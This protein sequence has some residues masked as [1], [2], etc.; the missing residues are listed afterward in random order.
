MKWGP[1]KRN[2]TSKTKV[3][4][5]KKLNRNDTNTNKQAA[6]TRLPSGKIVL[7]AGACLS[8][9]GL[10]ASGA[11]VGAA[12]ATTTT[13]RGAIVAVPTTPL[14]D[15]GTN[16]TAAY[17][18]GFGNDWAGLGA[19]FSLTVQNYAKAW[20]NGWKTTPSGRIA[21]GAYSQNYSKAG[22]NTG[23]TVK[24]LKKSVQ[25]VGFS[26]NA[27]N[28]NGVQR[29]DYC[30]KVAGF[31][32]DSG[33]KAAQYDWNIY[34]NKTFFSCSTVVTFGYVPVTFTGSL[35]GAANIYLTL[36]LNPD[37]VGLSGAGLAGIWGSASAGVGLPMLN[38]G[39]KAD[40]QLGNT[41]VDA[42][43]SI[44]PTTLSGKVD[45]IFDPVKIDLDVAVMSWCSTL[46]D[47]ELASYSSP[48]YT[49]P[50]IQF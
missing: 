42:S 21:T 19:D 41:M 34:V 5:M 10:A 6:W 3:K 13:T 49:W 8:F 33:S 2:K 14:P 27:Q 9:S 30:L 25:A 37:G 48:S 12:S 4:I 47:Y 22:I 45:L 18:Y 31:T 38:V 15:V 11:I 28:A 16:R 46:F 32:V 1:K 44:A 35:G 36:G 17:H 20:T 24:F 50:L 23:G 40:L 7:L 43:V 39:L 29:A 26:A